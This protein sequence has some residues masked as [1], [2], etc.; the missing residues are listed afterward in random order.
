[1]KLGAQVRASARPTSLTTY[2]P[3]VLFAALVTA[4]AFIG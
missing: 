1:M 2:L 4:L 3:L